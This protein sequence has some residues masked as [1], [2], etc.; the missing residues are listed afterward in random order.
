MYDHVKT[1]HDKYTSDVMLSM[2]HHSFSS[3]K[4]EA[5]NKAIMKV[6]PKHKTF[7]ATMSLS[8]RVNF[9]LV[10]DSLGYAEGINRILQKLG[11]EVDY[12][13]NPVSMDYWKRVDAFKEKVRIRQKSPVVKKARAKQ[14]SDGIRLGLLQQKHDYEKGQTYGT[15]IALDEQQQEVSTVGRKRK[16]KA[17]RVS[18]NNENYGCCPHCKR[19][20]HLRRTFRG[21]PYNKKNLATST[22]ATA[23][24]VTVEKSTA[25]LKKQGK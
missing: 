10:T 1:N 2:I 7:C 12:C 3:K 9:V 11:G 6:A 19:T 5:L 21:C 22:T 17:R 8:D 23:V 24:P 20:D 15:G 16:R 13:L 25:E 18:G 4:N 14:K